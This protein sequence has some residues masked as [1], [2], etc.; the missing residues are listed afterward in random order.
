MKIIL[1]K[2]NKMYWW[3]FGFFVHLMIFWKG[4][5]FSEMKQTI[6]GTKYPV[7]FF[8]FFLEGTVI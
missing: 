1:I 3:V 8:F 5:K 7:L 6:C 2:Q 4:K